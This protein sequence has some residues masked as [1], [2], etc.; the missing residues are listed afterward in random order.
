MKI[1]L[2]EC[3]ERHSAQYWLPSVSLLADTRQRSFFV[4]CQRLVLGK[5][6]DR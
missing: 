6:N 3:Q 2:A 1:Y 5:V 4:E